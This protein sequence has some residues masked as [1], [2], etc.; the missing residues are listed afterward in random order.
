MER[1]ML[2]LCFDTGSAAVTSAK[3]SLWVMNIELIPIR[4]EAE[5]DVHSSEDFP[6]SKRNFNESN[7]RHGRGSKWRH[8]E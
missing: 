8:N 5:L 3:V 2:S 7:R 6:K 4:K 1:E